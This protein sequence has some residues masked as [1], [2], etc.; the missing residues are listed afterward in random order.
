MILNNKRLFTMG[1][2]MLMIYIPWPLKSITKFTI[3]YL[4]DYNQESDDCSRL[5]CRPNICLKKVSLFL[6]Y[7]LI[8]QLLDYRISLN[9]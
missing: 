5:R 7:N 9:D 6:L 3:C 8:V 2:S 1:P 4:F